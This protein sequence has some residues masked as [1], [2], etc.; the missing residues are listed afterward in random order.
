MSKRSARVVLTEH[1]D[2]ACAD[3]LDQRVT[4]VRQS[5]EDAA[6]LRRELKDAEGLIVR[7]YTI[8]DDA[9]LAVAPKLKVVSG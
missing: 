1:L 2:D 6:A 7:T 8:V 9:V 3:W 4:L 5:H